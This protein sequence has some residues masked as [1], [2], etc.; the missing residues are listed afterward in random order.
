MRA[1]PAI[2][3]WA[4]RPCIL[5]LLCLFLHSPAHADPKPVPRL[6]VI[7]Q[8]YQQISI[9]R[10]GSEIARY[11]YGPA[12]RRPFV[13]PV[14]GPAGRSLTRMGHPR[15]PEGHSH[16]NSV[17]I[18]HVSVNGVNFWGDREK[19]RIAH[20][21]IE[22]LEDEGDDIASIMTLNHW[23][24]EADNKVLLMERRR[25]Q[26]Q[27]LENGEWL[28]LIDLQFTCREPVTFG[29]TPFGLIGV[30]MAKTIGTLDGGGTIR[31][32]EGQV[33]EKEIFWK[34]AKW[35]DYSGATTPNAIEGIT[36]MDHP[37]NPNHP[38]IFHVR[39]D[40]WMGSSFTHAEPR[41]LQPGETLRLRYGLYIH[42][43]QPS[44]E[45]LQQRWEQFAKSE[46]MDLPKPTRP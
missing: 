10:N 24:N 28:L 6:Q 26:A 18:S 5:L 9:Q 31:N 29:K 39:G 25:T 27:L 33:D 34:P 42:A 20:Q 19:G 17:W 35:V 40:G 8:P 44:R 46:L 23:I 16:H 13:F 41:T 21:R 1:R 7:P 43:G 30:R 4:A 22:A 36:L 12:L 11:H 15:D 32:S 3:A 2:V 14:I 45:Q 38:S 37:A